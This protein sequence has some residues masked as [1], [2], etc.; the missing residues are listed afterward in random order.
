M[1]APAA[2]PP[3]PP[4]GPPHE[5]PQDP[6]P[7]ALPGSTPP[8]SPGRQRFVALQHRDFRLIWIGQFISI[9]GT[10]MQAVAINWHIFEL[11]RGTTITLDLFGFHWALNPEALGL[12]GVGLARI[13]P[14]AIFA[15]LGGAL[16]DV[17]NRRTLLLW[18]N[19]AAALF[20]LVLAVLTF[21]GLGTIWTIYLLTSLTAA[22][23]AFSGPA[24][25]SL[26]PNLVP[27]DHLTNAISLNSL[28]FQTATI[29]GPALAGV[30][31]AAT[32]VGTVYALNAISFVTIIGALLLIRYRGGAAAR[33][34]G[35]NWAAI[36]EGWRFVRHTRI[37]WG[38]MMLDFLAT[39]FS[40]ANTMLPLVAGQ[41]LRVGADG[42]G[43]LATAQ[44]LG[45]FI[46]GVVL[47]L[48]KD[49]YRQGV[50][51]L[52][53]VALYGVATML[54][55]LSTSFVLS[56]VLFAMTGAADTVSTVIRQ[57]IR[58]MMTPD[59]LRGRMTGINQIFFMGGPQLGE[60]EA[61]VVAALFGVP[62]AIVSGGLATVALTGYIAYKYPNLRN[63]TRAQMAEDRA[64]AAAL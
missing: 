58:Q 25:Q 33:D 53:S 47:S 2:P 37:I 9:I 39:F 11:L 62:F 18:T 52:T 61:G 3:V 19:T 31:I 63:Y 51:L 13:I 57:T 45:S 56:Y 17:R 20:A 12:G 34:T 43:L 4:S 27:E 48:R 40:S 26:V 5:P 10:Q 28:S 14:I 24:F 23:A 46:T 54:F 35:L 42:Y 38:S 59:R 36:V 15:V 64:R 7:A 50:V 22:T 8:P 32:G 30:V 6:P 1:S 16:A 49:I 29:A 21:S 60:V 41:I 44:A 55:G